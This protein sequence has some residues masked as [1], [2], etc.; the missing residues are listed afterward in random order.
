[1][2]Y[3]HDHPENN[4]LYKGL[5]VNAGVTDVPTVNPYTKNRPKR[6]KFSVPDYVEGILAGNI[7][8]LSQAVTLVE[9]ALVNDQQI[10]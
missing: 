6:K 3:K 10:A 1:M 9:S 4:P 8:V 2:H 5:A 7:S